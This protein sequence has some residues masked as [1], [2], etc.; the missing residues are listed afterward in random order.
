MVSLR[1]RLE[2]LTEVL[3]LAN[4]GQRVVVRDGATSH[5]RVDARL[6]PR[7]PMHILRRE[8]TLRSPS[9]TPAD[10]QGSTHTMTQKKTTSRTLKPTH[11]ILASS[12]IDLPIEMFMT[13]C[14][15]TAFVM[16]PS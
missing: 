7:G 5:H 15:E 13:T 1:H 4:S 12:V 6:L 14:L 8:H 2:E 9:P 10:R 3:G 11:S 16:K